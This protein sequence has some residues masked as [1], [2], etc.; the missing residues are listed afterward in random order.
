M[1]VMAVLGF[2]TELPMRNRDDAVRAI[3]SQETDF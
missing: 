2:S 1:P 3:R